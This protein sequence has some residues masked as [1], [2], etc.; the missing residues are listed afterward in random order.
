MDRY[1]QCKY[2]YAAPDRN[3]PNPKLPKHLFVKWN[4]SVCKF[5]W[6][7]IHEIF[8]TNQIIFHNVY[9]SHCGNDGNLLSR[10]FDRNFVKATFVD[11]EVTEELISRKKQFRVFL[12][13]YWISHYTLEVALEKVFVKSINFQENH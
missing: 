6:D 7:Q 4:H 3:M 10:I 13:C 11:K 8:P 2:Y 9:C 12:C 5:W 1:V